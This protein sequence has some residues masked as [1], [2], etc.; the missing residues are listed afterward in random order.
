M[1]QNADFFVIIDQLNNFHFY[2]MTTYPFLTATADAASWSTYEAPKEKFCVEDLLVLSATWYRLRTTST[3]VDPIDTLVDTVLIESVLPEDREFAE[4]IRDHYSKKCL[5]WALMSEKLSV[6][7]NDLRTF[8]TSDRRTYSAS[9]LPLVFRL[10][11]FYLYDLMIDALRQEFELK[12]VPGSRATTIARTL[13]LF[14]VK[15]TRRKLKSGIKHEYW[16][17][18]E[19]GSAYQILI[20]PTNSCKSLWDR[21]FKLSSIDLCDCTVQPKHFDHFGFRHISKWSIST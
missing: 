19:S 11:E 17:K 4:K 2:D 5:I 6:F 13:T 1:L 8:I 16:L 12:A 18:D 14:P 21:E 20:E 3:Q 10:P 7:R 9:L 15:Y